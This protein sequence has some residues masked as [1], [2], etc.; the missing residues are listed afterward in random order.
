MYLHHSPTYKLSN[1]TVPHTHTRTH[2]HA[3][4]Q[5]HTHTHAFT[6]TCVHRH[7]HTHTHTVRR[8]HT[9]THTYTSGDHGNLLAV[10]VRTAPTP[11]GAPTPRRA[12]TSPSELPLR[13]RKTLFE[14]VASL[15]FDVLLGKLVLYLELRQ[16]HIYD[17]LGY[18]PP[19]L[20]ELKWASLSILR[21][22]P[23]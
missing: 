6:H 8:T 13:A 17:C 3:G 10:G 7:I 11:P 15:C 1:T 20:S 22:S 16:A 9:H 2:T 14:M 19:S 4:A 5:T 21:F 18:L 12:A 23:R